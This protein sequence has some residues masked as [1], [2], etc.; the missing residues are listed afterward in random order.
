VTLNI[1]LSAVVYHSCSSSTPLY[2]S[3]QVVWSA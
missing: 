3:A 2:Q 1:S